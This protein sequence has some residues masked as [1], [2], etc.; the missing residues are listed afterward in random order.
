MTEERQAVVF[1]DELAAIRESRSRGMLLFH[2]GKD[3]CG[4]W[5]VATSDHQAKLAMVDYIWPLKKISKRDRDNRQLEIMSKLFDE[6]QEMQEQPV[7]E[8]EPLIMV[9]T[10]D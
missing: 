1:D 6:M 3:G 5:V 4:P 7:S 2:A 8:P 10:E 9:V